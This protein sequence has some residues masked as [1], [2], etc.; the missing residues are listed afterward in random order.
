M[1]YFLSILRS[2]PCTATRLDR[3]CASA[4]YSTFH[5]SRLDFDNTDTS[6]VDLGRRG[7]CLRHKKYHSRYVS[8]HAAIIRILYRDN[9][10]TR[11]CS[12]VFSCFITVTY[13]SLLLKSFTRRRFDVT[14]SIIINWNVTCQFLHENAKNRDKYLKKTAAGEQATLNLFLLGALTNL[15]QIDSLQST[16]FGL[17]LTIFFLNFIILSIH[18]DYYSGISGIKSKI[19]DDAVMLYSIHTF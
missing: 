1:I 5:L 14:I 9:L 18:Y 12:V 4:F 19:N 17:R 11:I 16:T 3:S 13:S 6:D 10:F 2:I 15:C 8:K 7:Q